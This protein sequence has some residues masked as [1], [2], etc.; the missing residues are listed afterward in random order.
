MPREKINDATCEK[1]QCPRCGRDVKSLRCGHCGSQLPAWQSDLYGA[2]VRQIAKL[3]GNRADAGHE[4]GNADEAG[5]R[6][7]GES[8][9]DDDQPRGIGGDID[10][11]SDPCE[12]GTS[13]PENHSELSLSDRAAILRSGKQS[14]EHGIVYTPPHVAQFLFHLLSPIHPKI[15]MDVASG[16]GDLSRPW[17]DLA[18]IIEYELGFGQDFFQCSESIDT[19][20]V[21]CNPPF[22]SEKTFLRRILSVVPQTTPVAIIATHRVRLGS[23]T[24]S[25]DWRWCR[26][27]WPK[28][29]SIVSL[30]RGIFRGVN[31]TVEILLFRTPNVLPHYFL[32][33]RANSATISRNDDSDEPTEGNEP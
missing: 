22:G 23:Y 18:V 21:L 26:D 16:N 31:E 29:S 12:C 32:P 24:T 33:P 4:R 1:L 17:R 19:D 8:P 13:K 30:P 5:E 6:T 15:V 3:G 25:D 10:D 11:E 27:E 28:I 14:P 2:A 9:G 7:A 20:L